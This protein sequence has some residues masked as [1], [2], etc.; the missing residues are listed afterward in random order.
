MNLILV[1][2]VSKFH[3]SLEIAKTIV[4]DQI[5]VLH[6]KKPLKSFFFQLL[7]Y[8]YQTVMNK[9]VSIQQATPNYDAYSDI[10]IISPVWAGRLNAYMRQFLKEHPFVNKKV[11]I[12]ASCDGGY[13]KYFD[14]FEGFLDSSNKIVEKTVYVK[15][16]KQG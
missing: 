3:R 9:E 2:S 11:H 5:Q 15:G 13:E 6:Q 1:H 16:V 4:G 10:Y 12:I 7:L 14:S 8:G